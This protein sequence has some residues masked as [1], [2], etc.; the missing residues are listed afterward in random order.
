MCEAAQTS[1]HIDCWG[2]LLCGTGT[3]SYI[4]GFLKNLHLLNSVHSGTV[5]C[6]ALV[7]W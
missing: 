5:A 6:R 3:E 2:I 7:D 4:E 1:L